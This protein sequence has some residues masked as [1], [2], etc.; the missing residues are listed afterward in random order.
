[1]NSKCIICNNPNGAI[2]KDC[3]NRFSAAI[4]EKDIIT[5]LKQR[6]EGKSTEEVLTQFYNEWNTKLLLADQEEFKRLLELNK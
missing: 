2:C 6:E 3:L 1:M 4:H 5:M